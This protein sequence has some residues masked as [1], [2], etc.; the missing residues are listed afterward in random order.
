MIFLISFF[1]SLFSLIYFINNIIYNSGFF[2][3][4]ILIWFLA[5]WY[6]K[7]NFIF[8]LRLFTLGIIGYL[9]ALVKLIN[10]NAFFS[11]FMQKTQIIDITNVMLCF[12]NIAIFSSLIGL[13]IGEKIRVKEN[14]FFEYEPK[15]IFYIIF[16]LLI[17]VSFFISLKNPLIFFGQYAAKDGVK[18]PIHNLN[19][20]ANLLLFILIMY[21]FKFKQFY[22]QN[23]KTFKYLIYFSIFYLLIFSEL[24]RG[25]RMDFLNGII[26]IIVLFTFYNYKNLVIRLKYIIF[27]ILLVIILQI[28]G[29]VRSVIGIYG[30]DKAIEN[31]LNY[32]NYIKGAENTSLVLFNQGTINNIA[33]TFSGIIYMIKNHIIDFIYGNGYVEYILRIPPQFL[34]PNRPESYAWIFDKHGMASGG[35]IFELAMAYLNFGMIGVIIVPFIISFVIAYSYKLFKKNYFSLFNSI[36]LFSILAVFMRGEWYQTFTF[37]KSII[38]GYILLFFIYLSYAIVNNFKIKYRKVGI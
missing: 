6:Y 9:P 24:L 26:G 29:L 35:G 28:I 14:N 8:M 10:Q 34:Y 20:I 17:F 12:T 1:L 11:F 16:I 38:T 33:A 30:F 32:F 15:I 37:F 25:M 3:I 18:L 27:G 21:Y 7:K 19:T 2:F 36:L 13:Y 5:I 4:S 23:I 22:M 31:I